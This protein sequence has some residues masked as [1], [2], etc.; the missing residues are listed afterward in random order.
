M[1]IVN[2]EMGSEQ[3]QAQ[4]RIWNHI[5]N[6]INSM[7]LKCAIQLGIPD[8]IHHHGQPMTL[9]ALVSA[10]QIHPSRG[11]CIGRLMS[12]LVHSGFFEQQKLAPDGRDAYVLNHMSKLLLK[13]N[14]LSVTPFALVMLDPILVN[15]WHCLSEW[16]RNDVDPTPFEMAQG[17]SLWRYTGQE[18]RLN[19]FFND[20]MASDARLVAS[21]VVNEHKGVFNGITSLIDVG[22]GTGTMAKAIAIALPHIECTIFDLPHVVAG[23]EV[24]E[25]AIPPAD[26][27]LLK[28]ILHDW[29]DED[30][31]KILK[32]CKEA[33]SKGKGEK[34]RVIIID[35]VVDDPAGDRELIETQHFFDMLMMILASGR[36]RNET[37]WAKLFVAAGF[38]DYKITPILGLRSLIE[39]KGK[40]AST[41]VAISQHPLR[42]DDSDYR[43]KLLLPPPYGRDD[44]FRVPEE[45]RNSRATCRF[46]SQEV[47]IPLLYSSVLLLFPITSFCCPEFKHSIVS[48]ILELRIN[49][50]RRFK[51]WFRFFVRTL[52]GFRN[53]NIQDAVKFRFFR[54]FDTSSFL[55]DNP[56]SAAPFALAMLDTILMNP[57]HGLGAWLHNHVD[58]TPFEMMQGMSLWRYADNEQRLNRFFNEGMA[59][60]TRLVGS[61]VVNHSRGVFEGITS[62]VNVG[63]GTETMA[64]AIASTFLHIEFTNFDLPH[65][66]ANLELSKNVK[67]VAGDL[68][69]VI[70]LRMQCY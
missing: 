24:S 9:D 70:P 10:L 30:S 64:N 65:V 66:V 21:L 57:W 47:M 49:S 6:F 25:N 55:K 18:P 11:P 1:D 3:V 48:W 44:R 2:G 36:E 20:G 28:W 51:S 67:C 19:H 5:L 60:D 50:D 16:F 12:I 7:C 14:P 4:A 26:A 23:L 68:F 34:K 13:D 17:M 33:I 62:L 15:P 69:E 46:F 38:G 31:V 63:G 27:I 22:G 53:M 42:A 32:R 61:V 52:F 37:E 45:G 58:P 8:T 29:S 35:M 59:S 39:R 41:R 43:H 56:L 40:I 54:V